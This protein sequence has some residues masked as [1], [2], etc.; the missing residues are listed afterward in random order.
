MNQNRAHDKSESGN[1]DH[2]RILIRFLFTLS[3][4]SL[5][6]SVAVSLL[7]LLF[8][9]EH[10]RELATRDLIHAKELQRV[11]DI[12]ESSSGTIP[13][14]S[15]DLSAIKNWM[16]AVYERADAHGWDLPPIPEEVRSK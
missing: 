8:I 12:A 4:T 14:M 2:H 1:K 16:I 5:C 11:R 13:L 15:S 10:N 7:V 6:I 3:V 9:V